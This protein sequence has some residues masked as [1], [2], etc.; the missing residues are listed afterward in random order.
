MVWGFTASPVEK[1]RAAARALLVTLAATLPFEARLGKVGPLELTTVEAVLYATLAAWGLGVVLD[2]LAD[3]RELARRLA[4]LREPLATS[5]C[6]V[7][8]VTFAS[9]AGAESYRMPCLKFAL[10]ALSCMLLVFAARDLV[11]TTAGT[12]RVLTAVALGACVSATTAVVEL[13]APR[14]AAVW[15]LFREE[16]F[17]TFGLT[18]ATGV[19]GYPTIGAMYWEASLPIVLTL[20]PAWSS[21]TKD[22]A[23]SPGRGALASAWMGSAVL[24]SGILATATRSSLVGVA[25]TCVALALLAGRKPSLV[26]VR[27]LGA[28]VVLL[29]TTAAFLAAGSHGSALARRLRFWEDRRWFSVAYIV[30]PPAFRRVAAGEVFDTLVRVKNT[31]TVTW[32]RDGAHATHVAHRWY[33]LEHGQWVERTTTPTALRGVLPRDVES[34]ADVEV[35]A[36]AKAPTEPGQYR[37]SWDVVEENVTWFSDDGS[38]SPQETVVVGEASE[39]VPIGEGTR[40]TS[41][42]PPPPP[43]S[44]TLLWRAAVTLFRRHPLLGVGPD[45]FRRLYGDVLSSRDEGT[46]YSDARIHANSLYFETLA[47]TGIAGCVALAALLAA[48][49]VLVVRDVKRMDAMKLGAGL[50]ALAFF[51]HGLSD[52]FFEFTPTL[53]LFWLLLGLLPEEASHGPRAEAPPDRRS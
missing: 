5:A 4:S 52:D 38:P 29:L 26:R 53:G 51:V 41:L 2:V 22:A 3:R 24:V 42:A 17:D 1:V 28:L 34:G 8:V 45:N 20:P 19:F 40:A 21:W 25:I 13:L 47:D 10:R 37:L 43:P 44:R 33:R 27:A 16:G 50:A 39:V 11:R 35:T 23:A 31:G 48:L 32:A 6:L 30:E 18:R 36:P 46:V 7:V 12:R 14:T 9:A 49:V 15:N